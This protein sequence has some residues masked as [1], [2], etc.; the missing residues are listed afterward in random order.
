MTLDHFNALPEERQLVAVLNAGRYLARR[1]EA[2]HAVNLYHLF[3]RFFLELHYDSRANEITRLRA[4]PNQNRLDHYA[5]AITLRF[6]KGAF[7]KKAL[8]YP[9]LYPKKDKAPFLISRRTL[10]V[11]E[12]GLEPVRP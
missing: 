3:G 5:T 4:F 9:R 10:L 11:P 6:L 8:L 7:L 12:T 1:Y 2:G